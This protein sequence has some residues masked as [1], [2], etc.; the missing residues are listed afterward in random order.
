M[1]QELD[2]NRQRVAVYA[3]CVNKSIHSTDILNLLDIQ[4]ELRNRVHL[5]IDWNQGNINIWNIKMQSNH[6][7]KTGP[8]RPSLIPQDMEVPISSHP[9]CYM[10][11]PKCGVEA[12]CLGRPSYLGKPPCPCSL[13]PPLLPACASPYCSH[14]PFLLGP[15]TDSDKLWWFY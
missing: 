6:L 14:P 15:R 1:P 12:A 11:V 13:F 5:N 2:W 8:W 10:C 4:E 7:A 3:L 9:G